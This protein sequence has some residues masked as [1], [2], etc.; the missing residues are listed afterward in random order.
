MSREPGSITPTVKLNGLEMKR[1]EPAISIPLD[2]KLAPATEQII[3]FVACMIGDTTTPLPKVF[4]VQLTGGE[5]EFFG[6]GKTLQVARHNTAIKLFRMSQSLQ[7]YLRLKW[8]MK[9]QLEQDPRRK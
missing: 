5:R 4:Y 7:N 6:E 8:D 2:Q 3:I 1:G 9:L